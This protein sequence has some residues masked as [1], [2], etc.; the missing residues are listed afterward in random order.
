LTGS[1]GRTSLPGFAEDQDLRTWIRRIAIGIVAVVV[2]AVLLGVDFVRSFARSVPIYDG[3]VM[4]RA[5]SA[6][7]QILRD[8]YAVPHIF[9]VSFQDA[10]FGLGYAHAEDRL[11][12]MEMAR[13]FVQGRLAELFGSQAIP[14]DVLMR[15]IG[16]YAAAEEA[17]KHLAPQSQRVLGAYADGVNAY[18]AGHRGRWPI[19]FALAAD[20]PPERWTPV[21]SIAVMKGMAWQLSGNAYAEAARAAL[22]P[23]LGRQ[24]VQDFFPPFS[25]APL[26]AW[27][28]EIYTT[29]RTGQ[30][31]AP[32][33]KTASDNWVVA[34]RRSDDGQPIVANDPHLGF[35]IPSVW[36]LAHL[37]FQDQ[38]ISGGTLAGIPAIIAG[39]NRHLAWGETNTGPDTQDLFLERLNPDNH[40]EYQVPGGWAQFDSRLEIIKVRFGADRKIL[41]RSTRHGPVMPDGSVFGRATPEGYVVS[42]AWTALAPDDTTLDAVLGIDLSQNSSDFKA[43]ALRFVTPMQNTVYADDSGHIGLVLPGR[44]PLRSKSNDAMGLVPAPG[45]DGRY[46]WHGFIPPQEMVSVV[47][48]PSG[49]IATAN[50]KT[51]PDGYTY[52]LTR[53]WEDSYRFDR[54]EQILSQSEK[55]SPARFV[56]MQND[57]IDLYAIELKRRLLAAAPFPEADAPAAKLIAGWNGAMEANR[58]EPLIF[59]A[60]ARALARRIY[61]DELGPRFRNFWGYRAEFTLRVLD[62]ID[63]DQR[64]CDDR[65]TPQVEDCGSRI[66]LALHDA[67][68]ELDAQYGNDPTRWRWG[69]PHKALNIQQPFGSFPLIGW[70]FN[71]EISISGGP[72]TL[73]RADNAMASPQ[74]Y[75]AIHGAGYRGVYDLAD[76]NASRYIISTGQSGN[77]FS[78]HY[79]DL[80]PVWARGGTIAIPLDR[81]SIQSNTVHSLILRPEPANITSKQARQ[82]G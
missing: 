44:V 57:I 56:A 79:D 12:Q 49:Q 28:D 29:T 36:Y 23:V 53:E 73:L 48:P 66:R 72:F 74:P 35:T 5:V 21:D 14:S 77:L 33:D 61:S 78:P 3:S 10:A 47:D 27:L 20:S 42:L 16:L 54:I 18:I 51:V 31:F 6:P 58:P 76:P 70:Y 80:M 24:G 45:W 63:G 81:K 32:P 7:V 11:W 2:I 55:N 4:V 75:A 26:P 67:V 69:V 64:W 22:I 9:A 52:A 46:D 30:A 43:A 1:S 82:Q 41:V 8:K 40:R 15:S 13:R 50:N 62:G 71:R 17:L 25:E 59:A 37:S 65:A 19:E 68:T 38:D 34:G 60:W 39:R